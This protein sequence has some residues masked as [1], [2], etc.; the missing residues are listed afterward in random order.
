MKTLLRFTVLLVTVLSI[1]GPGARPAVPGPAD[2]DAHRLPAGRRHRHHR[3]HRGAKALREPGAADPRPRTAGGATGMIAAELAAKAAPDGYTIMMA[4]IAAMSIL[5]SLYPK[6]AYDAHRDFAPD[7]AGRDRAESAGGASVGAGKKREGAD[8]A[9][10]SASRAAPLR[11][12][13]HRH[14][15]APRRGAVQAAGEGGH[16]ARPLQGQRAIHRGPRRRTRSSRFRLGAPGAPAR[17]QRQAARAGGNLREALFAAAR[18]SDRQ[19]GRRAGLRHEHVV[20]TGRASGGEQ[21][22]HLAAAGRNGQ[23]CCGCP[24]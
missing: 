21:G 2:P 8:R 17:A 22:R 24:T 16:A 13:G 1:A 15:A 18:H 4:H 20:G 3:P 6:M 9:R 23:G 14:R 12:A 5:P 11:L 7:H 19:R 10:E